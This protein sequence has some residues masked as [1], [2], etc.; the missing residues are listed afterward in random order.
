LLLRFHFNLLH[1]CANAAADAD[2][3]GAAEQISIQKTMREKRV[4]VRRGPSLG[5][6]R[7]I[8]D[9]DFHLIS[10]VIVAVRGRTCAATESYL[11]GL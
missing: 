7:G 11:E 6:C 5:N 3:Y 8:D 2:A 1:F 9:D 4:R 10:P